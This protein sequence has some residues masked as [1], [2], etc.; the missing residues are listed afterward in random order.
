MSIASEIQ[1][2]SG[3]REDI[4][5]AIAAKGVTVPETA[6]LSS[7]P[8]LIASITAGGGSDALY[9]LNYNVTL[10]AMQN[11]PFTAEQKV[12]T[13]SAVDDFTAQV[14][15][16]FFIKQAEFANFEI[17]ASM[18]TAESAHDI[19]I[20]SATIDGDSEPENYVYWEPG[21]QYYKPSRNLG[22]YVNNGVLSIP[23]SEIMDIWSEVSSWGADSITISIESR[24]WQGSNWTLNGCNI[25]GQVVTGTSTANPYPDRPTN[26]TSTL[27]NNFTGVENLGQ[28]G[29]GIYANYSLQNNL[30]YGFRVNSF[31]GSYSSNYGGNL[32]NNTVTDSQNAI[33]SDL[34]SNKLLIDS[35]AP[36]SA[37]NFTLGTVTTTSGIDG[38]ITG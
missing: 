36:N 4:K 31:T 24:W 22:T 28:D 17:P 15:E 3:C 11:I 20:L 14:A 7:C 5:T 27:T 10:T 33:N 35:V 12:I 26:I 2:I 19:S 18:L 29:N 9:K 8:V 1:R 25:T 21:K 16:D 6:T 30:R 38:N 13:T 23:Y 34:A 37:Y 32:V